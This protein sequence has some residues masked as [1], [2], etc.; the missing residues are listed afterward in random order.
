M[1]LE[2][3]LQV[4]KKVCASLTLV[5][6]TQQHLIDDLLKTN[7]ALKLENETLHELNSWLKTET[8][9]AKAQVK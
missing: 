5:V 8:T 7:D 1:E 6:K 3:E 2:M 9:L 4:Y